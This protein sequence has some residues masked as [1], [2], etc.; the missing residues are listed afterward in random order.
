MKNHFETI[1]L[2]W[3][4]GVVKIIENNWQKICKAL[5]YPQPINISIQI[6]FYSD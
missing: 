1:I 5:S 6:N 2:N 3:F 4:W